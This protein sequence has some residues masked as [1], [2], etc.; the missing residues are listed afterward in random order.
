MPKAKKNNKKPLIPKK[1]ASKKA[2]NK[3]NEKMVI[4]GSFEQIMKE[5]IS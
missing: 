5:L 1:K 4:N 3:Y 2:I